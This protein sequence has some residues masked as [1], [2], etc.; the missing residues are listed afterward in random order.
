MAL[1]KVSANAKLLATD[2]NALKAA[3]DTELMRRGGQGSV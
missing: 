1:N 3:I 2:I